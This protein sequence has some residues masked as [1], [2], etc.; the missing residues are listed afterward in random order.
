MCGKAAQA[1]NPTFFMKIDFDCIICM[2]STRI[3]VKINYHKQW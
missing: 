1:Q 3:K 2:M